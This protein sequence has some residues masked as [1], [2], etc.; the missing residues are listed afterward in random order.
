MVMVRKIVLK[1]LML[2]TRFFAV[3]IPGVTKTLCDKVSRFQVDPSVLQ[4]YSMAMIPTDIPTHALP[5]NL[6]V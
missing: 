3:H 6:N 5:V 1:L 4:S 2:N